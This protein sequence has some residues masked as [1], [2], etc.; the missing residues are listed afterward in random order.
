MIEI[1]KN[2]KLK[3]VNIKDNILVVDA[4]EHGRISVENT[5]LLLQFAVGQEV[6]IFLMPAGVG[7]LNGYLGPSLASCNEFA[8]LQ[9][10]ANTKVGSFFDIGLDKDLFCPFKEQKNDLE[11]GGYYLVYVYLDVDTNR[12]VASTRINRFIVDEPPQLVEQQEVTAFVLNKTPLGYS[13]IVDNKYRGLL[14]DNE[15]FGVLESGS[16]VSA[17]VHKV[18][19]DRR[20]DL[21][22]FRNDSSDIARF[23]V[24]IVDY[25]RAHA[26]TMSINDDTSPEVIYRTFGISKKNFKKALGGLY[27]KRV[28][29]LRGGV[30]R[31][32]R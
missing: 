24:A 11:I 15:V 31:L 30:V 23:E 4:C 21:R 7:V 10:V 20:V 28:V 8:R 14:Y 18:R 3:I 13:V 17:I 26:G 32:L 9:V 12:L 25:L 29:D 2:Q 5:E 22:L 19:D 16:V 6:D 27:R 1:G